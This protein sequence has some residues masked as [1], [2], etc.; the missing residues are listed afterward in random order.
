MP[1][2][3]Y[4][5]T[6]SLILMIVSGCREQPRDLSVVKKEESKKVNTGIKPEIVKDTDTNPEKVNKKIDQTKTNTVIDK[7]Q[8]SD[9]EV[10]YEGFVMDIRYATANNF[11]KKVIYDCPKCLLR[12]SAAKALDEANRHLTERFKVR[13]KL[14]D[15]YRPR[16]YQQRLW[17][18]VPNASYVTPPAKGSM[19]SRGMAVDLTLVDE[20]GKEL[21][22]GTAFDFF[23]EEAHQGYPKHS[24]AVKRNRYILRSTMEKYGFSPIRTEW[25]HFSYGGKN[26]PLSDFVWKCS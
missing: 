13:I 25:W 4:I 15:C 23:G 24:D 1:L 10:D 17:D 18:I 9:L 6:L 3:N 11:T 19:H 12:P 26:Y 22:M 2:I 20:D 14:F 21:D 16:P 5:L 8:W 7:E